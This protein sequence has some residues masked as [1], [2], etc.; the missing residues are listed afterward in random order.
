MFCDDYGL[1]L[2]TFINYYNTPFLHGILLQSIAVSTIER[3]GF[4]E[5]ALFH[6]YEGPKFSGLRSD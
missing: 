1:R 6:E 4:R 5:V 3:Q 2:I